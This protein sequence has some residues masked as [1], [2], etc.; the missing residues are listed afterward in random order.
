MTT[1]ETTTEDQPSPLA[2]PPSWAEIRSDPGF[3]KLEPEKKLVA[4]SRWHDDAYN[5]A[6]SLPDW[7]DHENDFNVKAQQTQDELAKPLGGIHPDEARVRVAANTLA[8]QEQQLGRPLTGDERRA[9]LRPLG[10]DVWKTY[11][12]HSTGADQAPKTTLQDFGHQVAN[13]YREAGAQLARAGASTNA[14][15]TTPEEPHFKDLPTAMVNYDKNVDAKRQMLAGLPDTPE[16]AA[17]RSQLEAEVKGLEADRE[18]VEGRW[19]VKIRSYQG[20]VQDLHKTLEKID[21]DF[22]VDPTLKGTMPAKAARLAAG[23][24]LAIA[25]GAIPGVGLPLMITQNAAS[26]WGN[27]LDATNGDSKAADKALVRNV[28]A[29]LVFMGIAHGANTGLSKLLEQSGAGPLQSLAVRIAGGSAANVATGQVLAGGEAAIDAPTGEKFKAFLDAV[30]K[31]EFDNIA[32]GIAFG[33]LGAKPMESLKL[34]AEANAKARDR[35]QAVKDMSEAAA[36]A[37]VAPQAAELRASGAPATADALETAAKT[38]AAADPVAARKEQ[39]RLRINELLLDPTTQESHAEMQRLIAEQQTLGEQPGA[40]RA[41][42]GQQPGEA[43]NIQLNTRLLPDGTYQH[44]FTIPAESTPEQLQAFGEKLNIAHLPPEAATAIRAQLDAEIAQRRGATAPAAAPATGPKPETA[45]SIVAP[46]AAPQEATGPVIVSTAIRDRTNPTNVVTGQEWNSGHDTFTLKA[47]E[48]AKIDADTLERG[49]LVREPDGTERFA[50]REEAAPI[51]AASGQAPEGVTKLR[52]Q[53]LVQTLGSVAEAAPETRAVVAPEGE[54]LKPAP[55]ARPLGEPAPPPSRAEAAREHGQKLTPDE[56]A[57]KVEAGSKRAHEILDETGIP[58]TKE[59]LHKLTGDASSGSKLGKEL[60][61]RLAE[62]FPPETVP[63]GSKITEDKNNLTGTKLPSLI[64]ESGKVRPQFTNDPNIT[65]QQIDLGAAGTDPSTRLYIPDEIAKNGKVNPAIRYAKDAEGRYYVLGS[66]V[67]LPDGK[68]V[69]IDKP[70]TFADQYQTARR[71][72]GD[73]AQAHIGLEPE[74][75]QQVQ[76]AVAKGATERKLD[77]GPLEFDAEVAT[78]PGQPGDTVMTIPGTNTARTPEAIATTTLTNM[79]VLHRMGIGDP[80]KVENPVLHAI[81]QISKDT[82]LTAGARALAKMLM[83]SGVDFSKVKLTLEQKP[84]AP[85]A[86]LYTSARDVNEGHIRLNTASGHRNGIAATLLHEAVHHTTIHKMSDYYKRTPTEEKAYKQIVDA[87]DKALAEVYKRENGGKTGSEEDLRKFAKAQSGDARIKQSQKTEYYGLSNPKEFVAETL[88]SL[89]F[90]K[91]LT[92]LEGSGKGPKGKVGNLLNTLISSL[93]QLFSGQEIKK[94]SLLDNALDNALQLVQGPTEQGRIGVVKTTESKSMNFQERQGYADEAIRRGLVDEGSVNTLTGAELKA[95]VEGKGPEVPDSQVS[96]PGF[97]GKDGT[98]HPTADLSRGPGFHDYDSMVAVIDNSGLTSKWIKAGSPDPAKFLVENGFARVTT[99]SGNGHPI[100]VEGNLNSSQRAMLEGASFE[101]GAA[102]IHEQG[103]GRGKAIFGVEEFMTPG[104]T[105]K[106]PEERPHVAFDAEGKA[107]LVIP[108]GSSPEDLAAMSKTLETAKLSEEDKTRLASQLSDHLKTQIQ[109]PAPSGVT[110]SYVDEAR[111]KRGLSPRMEPLRRAM[112]AVWDEAMAAIDK[113]PQMGS[114]LVEDFTRVIGTRRKAGLSDVETA[115]LAHEQVMRE[116]E[117]DNAVDA[118]N[119][120]KTD[121]DRAS[122]QARLESARHAVDQV[123]TAADRSGT[124]AGQNLAMRRILVNRDYTLARMEAIR[125]AA[126]D[127]KPLTEQQAKEVADLHTELDALRKKLDDLEAAQSVKTDAAEVEAYEKATGAAKEKLAKRIAKKAGEPFDNDKALIRYK[128]LLA[129]RQATLEAKIAAGDLS[130]QTRNKTV[131]D[132]EALAMKA[133]YER[134][135]QDFDRLVFK[136]EFNRKPRWE[137]YLSHFN[138]Y[139][140]A[141]VLSSYT[142]FDKLG[143]AAITRIALNSGEALGGAG[144][145]KIP[146][147]GKFTADSP[148][149]GHFSPSVE[150]KSLARAFTKG[151]LD[152]AQIAKTG[153]TDLDVLYGRAD[154]RPRN[155]ALEA[156]GRSHAIVK[157]PAFRNTFEQ[158]MAYRLEWA[159]RQSM[160][161]YDPVFMNSLAIDAY[162]DAERSIFKNSNR[163]SDAWRA[164]LAT[165]E[166]KSK[167]TGG[168]PFL[169]KVGATALRTELPIVNVPTNIASEAFEYVFGSA[170]GSAR[171]G[172]A[173]RVGFDNVPPEQKQVILRNLSKGLIFNAALL[174]MAYAPHALKMG[175]LYTQDEPKRKKK[176]LKPGDGQLFGVTIPAH[177]LHAPIFYAMN[178]V[179]TMKRLTDPHIMG[180]SKKAESIPDASFATLFALADE[181]PFA[182]MVEQVHKFKDAKTRAQTLGNMV[183]SRLIPQI[184]QH[185]AKR[186]DQNAAGEVQKRKPKSSASFNDKFTQTLELGIPG[187][188]KKVPKAK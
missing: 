139:V 111:A 171:L 169:A 76:D 158:S 20:A 156:V 97:I 86:G 152:I 70:D 174:T 157:A 183:S 1:D 33:V 161:I 34:A 96:G 67:R 184:I 107:N 147:L 149:A 61:A 41:T 153:K 15:F 31:P 120:A 132:A 47:L 103:N 185:E 74:K 30:N 101:N 23:T 44:A 136:D 102:V 62:E 4:F 82:R 112:G 21:P 168:T 36:A 53:D 143:M 108:E 28:A 2:A 5:Y 113:D 137:R 84:N 92:S 45:G 13:A 26:A 109:K 85:H 129:T 104:E 173:M 181:I 178:S 80:T 117:F 123:F 72:R 118:V 144:I 115:V 165:L 59:E 138:D 188:R 179:E 78:D 63:A 39:I 154:V 29:S 127:G 119:D 150:A 135:R 49:F 81:K 128:K 172:R 155:I 145:G 83:K 40:T 186:E 57:A 24:G 95:M 27:T 175:G 141:A 90:Q 10:Q 162:H 38:D 18:N 114:R 54:A 134:T 16:F 151:A 130:K 11:L 148:Y 6:Q 98:F 64:D 140:K 176:D 58:P 43:P 55:T 142:V 60:K 122:A 105:P 146:G 79:D 177:L 93:K 110:N 12:D 17:D 56:K 159:K 8:S 71:L 3:E 77:F 22:H 37:T 66:D 167:G 46:P 116:N 75:L 89:Q 160:P 65:A 7:K 163:A 73:Q 180:G 42:P 68:V 35:A 69:H 126:N 124:I 99:E 106:A 164:T 87:Y 166:R 91:L 100:Y 48:D 125:R 187:L 25:E 14:F 9:A 32:Q 88:S 170:L 182:D 131:L 50:T 51:A 121:I 19:D 94:G 133:K 52:S